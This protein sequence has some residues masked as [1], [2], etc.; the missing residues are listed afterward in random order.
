[1]F[2]KSSGRKIL[3]GLV[4]GTLLS[5]AVA[6]VLAAEGKQ[7]YY[8]LD[9]EGKA[10]MSVREKECITAPQ[11][12]NEPTK[13]F[14]ECGDVKPV[15]KP[16]AKEDPC[17]KDA[18]NDG[19]NDCRDKCANTPAGSKVDV[20][21][22]RVIGSTHN[23]V[24]SGDVTFKFN[25]S[26]LSPQGKAQL[27]K[28]AAEI[29]G[30]KSNLQNV[31]INGHTDSVGSDQYNLT[32]SDKRSKSVAKYLADKGVPKDKLFVKGMGESKPIADNKTKEGRAKNRRVE[33]AITSGDAK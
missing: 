25:K 11:S 30:L 2:E 18:D 4:T 5:A 17:A 29:L 8:V 6:S 26:D 1:M 16:V 31:V 15:P 19:V 21:G 9:S 27:D 22:C 23:V 20:N 12:P 3:M 28:V 14:V 10:V 24:L 33:I 7:S 32:L 13:E